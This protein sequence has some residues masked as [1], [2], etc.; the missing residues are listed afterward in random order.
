[1]TKYEEIEAKRNRFRRSTV[2]RFYTALIIAGE[3]S[4]QAFEQGSQSFSISQDPIIKAYVQTYQI[5][6]VYFAQSSLRE[7]DR[8]FKDA[9]QDLRPQW[10]IQMERYVLNEAGNRIKSVTDY[11]L[12]LV[13]KTINEAVNEGLG[14]RET[15]RNIRN[16]WKEISR[17]RSEAIARTEIV[18]ASNRG[19]LVGAQA[20]GIDLVKN[21]LATP[22]PRTRESHLIAGR[23][24]RNKRVPLDDP[25][26]VGGEELD[27]PGDPKGSAK[28]TIQCRC[29]LVYEPV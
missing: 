8:L 27:Y 24:E 28:E 25:F 21:W 14:S 26:I 13:R 4:I 12:E 6:G 7:V 3:P 9:A 16:K 1:M 22:G 23:D 18:T 5:V 2:S 15:A 20:A 17:T 11:T 19:S 10:L 29:T